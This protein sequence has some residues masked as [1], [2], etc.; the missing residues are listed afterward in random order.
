MDGR[1]DI[2]IIGGGLNGLI[3]AY[4]L[5]R[6]G[7]RPLVLERREAIGGTCATGTIAPGFRVPTLL[8]ATGPLRPGLVA[9]MGLER[10]GLALLEPEA[11]LFS[12]S[13]DGRPLVLWRDARRAAESIAAFSRADAER[14]PQFGEAVTRLAGALA[15]LLDMTP[16]DIDRPGFRDITALLGTARQVRALGPRDIHRLLRWMPMAIADVAAEW[17]D[18]EVLRAAIG[19]RAVLGQAAGPW[20]AGTGAVW[21]LR[22]A[23]D[24]HVA[25]SVVVPRGGPGALAEAVAAAARAAGAE[26][27]TGAEVTRIEVEHG[28]ATGVTL[29]SGDR[30]DVPTVISGLDP[31]GTLLRLVDGV[32]MGPDMR[33]RV[34]N[35][36]TRGVTAKVNL[37][38]GGLPAFT[39]LKALGADAA[40]AL[41]GRI[42][43]APEID[44]VERAYDAS[45]YGQIPAQPFL[46][47]TIPSIVDPS[48]APAGRHVMSVLAQFVPYHLADGGWGDRRE[49]LGDLVVK[50]LA[51]RAPDLPGLVE[52]RQVITPLDL[53]E[54]WGLSEGHIFQGEEALDQFFTMRPILGYC[55]YRS[56]IRGLYWCGAGTHPGGGL[57]GA[58]G[59][60]AAKAVLADKR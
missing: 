56:P 11:R 23:A 9:E 60:N 34:H 1:T 54:G 16:P 44:Y 6:A 52:H 31:K 49:A 28:A 57:T 46:E 18:T 42:L 48:L 8:H 38:L 20:S 4:Y 43:V 27:R 15:G 25:G 39:A 2:L 17:F 58:N 22:A 33:R 29:K 40:Q 53:E 13:A 14:Y 12:A 45:K 30:L 10:H 26:V 35:I 37:A 50:T 36:R 47:A 19:A 51:E 24:P 21:F 41:G 32:H 59:R 55:R 7:R 5:A 3:A